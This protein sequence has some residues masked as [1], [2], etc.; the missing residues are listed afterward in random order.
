MRPPASRTRFERGGPIIKALISGELK[1]YI[2]P[3]PPY[4]GTG[5]SDAVDSVARNFSTYKQYGA[6]IRRVYDSRDA[7]LMVSW[8][9]DYGSE[10]TGQSIGRVHIKVGLGRNNCKGEWRA[11]DAKTVN[12][13]LWHELGHSMGYGHSSNPNNVMYYQTTTGLEVEQ[14]ISELIP[15]G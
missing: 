3:L 13:I 6:S 2:E 14:E 5:V 8:V 7:D 11:F 12:K 15:A 1:F 10:V 4:A 9:R